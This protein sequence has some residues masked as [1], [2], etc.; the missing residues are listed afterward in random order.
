MILSRALHRADGSFGGVIIAVLPLARLKQLFATLDLGASGAVS[1]RSSDLTLLARHPGPL[2][3]ANEAANRKVSPEL[4]AAI[5]AHPAAGTYVASTVM[6]GVERRNAYLRFSRYP[7]YVIVGLGTADFLDEWRGDKARALAF[8]L[9]FLTATGGLTAFAWTHWRRRDV[10]EERLRSTLNALAEGVVF[11]QQDGRIIEANAAAERILGLSRDQLLGLSSVDPRWQAVNDQGQPMPGEQH[12]AMVTLRT[13]VAQHRRI[14]GL[15]LPGD[16]TRWLSVNTRAVGA[17]DGALAAVVASFTDITASRLAEDHLRDSEARLAR[18]FEGTLQGFWDWNM[19]TGAIVVSPRFETMLGYR[20]GEWVAAKQTWVDH[21]HPD[22]VAPTLACFEAHLAGQTPQHSAEFRMRDKSGDWRWIH[23]LGRVASRDVSGRPVLVSGT[24]TDITERKQ[25]EEQLR[26][27][28][29]DFVSVLE[30]TSDFIYFKD[31]QSRF[32]FCSQTLARITGHAHWRDMQGKHDREVFPP[33]LAAV[34]EAEEAPVFEQGIALLNRV[35]PYL[36]EAGRSGWVNTN[37]WPVFG[38]DGHSVIGIFGISRVV[39]EQ[40]RLEDELRRLAATDALTGVASRRSFMESVRQELARLERSAAHPSSVL[41]F[42]LD[43]FKLVNDHH[44]HPAGDAV[45]RHVTTL[46][47]DEARRID[48]VGRL[49]GEEFAVLLVG[50]GQAEAK[51]FAERLRARIAGTPCPLDGAMVGV[52]VSIGIS[53]LSA[54][55]DSPEQVLARADQ[56][57]YRA[58]RQGRNQV[59]AESLPPGQGVPSPAKA[60]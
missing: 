60:G 49:G 56:A 22:D 35:N 52:T 9:L 11:Q 25:L 17:G 36:D 42:D 44:G 50:S 48:I 51:V 31:R 58:K 54:T 45:L 16:E 46:A 53:T 30:S 40:K 34:Y 55:D 26:A 15:R 6:D 7:L 24:H 37:K 32:R 33:A 14:M 43:H 5:A 39:T 12:P 41:M 13:G 3:M 18:V 1:L 29:K 10:Q 19:A 21:V 27:M 28:N 2:R 57:M 47:S 8:C 20:P 38:D 59:E 4:E 23:S